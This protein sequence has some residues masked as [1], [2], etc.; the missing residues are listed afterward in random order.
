MAAPDPLY[1]EP[2]AAH[3][4]MAANGLGSILRATWRKA[5]VAAEEG[6]EQNLVGPNEELE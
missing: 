4:P 6:T 1:G 2:A 5:T 3:C